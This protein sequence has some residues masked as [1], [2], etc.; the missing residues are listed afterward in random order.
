MIAGGQNTQKVREC[1][2]LFRQN[3]TC[4]NDGRKRLS[5]QHS[6][7]PSSTLKISPMFIAVSLLETGE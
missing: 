4:A 1:L 2:G 6:A 7:C 5:R 3:K